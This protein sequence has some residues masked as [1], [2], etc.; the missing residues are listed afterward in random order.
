MPIQEREYLCSETTKCKKMNEDLNIQT[1][2]R[3]WK[4]K[5]IVSGYIFKH[6]L[7]NTAKYES[8]RK[9]K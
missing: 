5:E 3:K 8:E 9:E 4:N 7:L 6:E 1:R 2:N